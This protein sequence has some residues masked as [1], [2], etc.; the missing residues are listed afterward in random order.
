MFVQFHFGEAERLK[1]LIR[2]FGYDASL[3]CHRNWNGLTLPLTQTRIWQSGQQIRQAAELMLTFLAQPFKER[4]NQCLLIRQFEICQVV[5]VRKNVV[6][7]I[8]WD[9]VGATVMLPTKS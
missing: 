1:C 3:P 5:W 9:R 7:N 2:S 8:L 6:R 4:I